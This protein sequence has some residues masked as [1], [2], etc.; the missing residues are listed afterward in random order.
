VAESAFRP[1]TPNPYI[2]G[3]PVRDR[4]MFF[5]RE[6]EF[7]LVRKRFGDSPH[8]GIIVFCGDRRSGK[9]SIL[10]QVMQG[11]LGPHFLPVLIDMQSMAIQSEA[12]FYRR[13]TSEI[14]ASLPERAT[15]VRIPDYRD[16]HRAPRLFQQFVSELLEHFPDRRPI[17]LVD[18]YELLETKIEAGVLSPDVLHVFAGILEKH[19]FFFVFTGSKNLEERKQ[20]YWRIL[21]QSIHRRISYLER[22]DAV[23]L[24]RRPVEGRVTFAPGTIDLLC[25][26]GAGQPFYTQALCQS[27]VDHLNEHE[28]N[29]AT[30]EAVGAVV[31]T[32]INN[33]FPQMIFGWDSL[34]ADEKLTLALLAESLPAD[35]AWAR[36]EDLEQTLRARRYPL[37]VS[38]ARLEAALEEL[39][40]REL[41]IKH[42]DVQRGFAYRMDLWRQWIL[43][44]HSVWQ[45]VR[46]EKIPTKRLASPWW[47]A[48]LVG[49]ALALAAISVVVGQRLRDA[50][51]NAA[52]PSGPAP[53]TVSL[54]PIPR[55]AF[56]SVDGEAAGQ[57]PLLRQLEPDREH[58][59]RLAATGYADTTLLLTLEAGGS[60]RREVQLRPLTGA[61]RIVTE[62]PAASVFVDGNARGESPLVVASLDVNRAHDIRAEVPGRQT[63]S[64]RVTPAPEDTVDCVL[65][66]DPV[67]FSTLFSTTP[68]GAAL[69]IDGQSLGTTPVSAQGLAEGSHRVV[70]TLAGYTP[71]DTTLALSPA[72]P[73]VSLPLKPEPPGILVV[74]GETLA[75]RIFI[76][77]VLVVENVHNS[78][79]CTLSTGQHMVQVDLADTSITRPIRVESAR[80][81][82]YNYVRNEVQ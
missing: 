28:S 65:V 33:P 12:E 80:R 3:N 36:V 63:A 74:L 18:E 23:E 38:R 35:D 2:V 16:D 29:E 45:V 30:P 19:P 27:L 57:G 72:V 7:Q 40:Q 44:E 37:A 59:F 32:I 60:L 47:R 51:R 17:L 69:T 48:G 75:R 13:I 70:A 43:R 39:F 24:I 9:T 82:I 62:P 21:G 79:P 49:A 81:V 1:I 26:L 68:S 50:G 46:E 14:V 73:A 42:A 78:G 77:E 64:R 8:G 20:D 4:S 34:S 31:G 55:T 52:G 61:I 71:V 67:R 15:E 25:R 10:F 22:S 58:E 54:D 41:L 11:R 6:S 56:I 53:A 76:D 5:G 66:L